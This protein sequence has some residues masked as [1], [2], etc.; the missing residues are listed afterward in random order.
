MKFNI[1]NTEAIYRRM[2]AEPDESRRASIFRNELIA[3]Y[4]GL[5]QTFGGG[6]GMAMFRQWAIYTP[7]MLA[8]G[9]REALVAVLDRLAAHDAWNQA[10]SALDDARVAFEPY[11]DRIPLDTIQFGLFP[12][13]IK[14]TLPM[15]RG[16]SGFG[17]VPGYIMVTY[18]DPNEYN[19]PRLKGAVVHELHHNVRF[20]LFPFTMMVTVGEYIIAEG[21]AES[22][23]AELYGED[24]VG[25]YVTDFDGAELATARRVIGNALH[26]TGFNEVRGYIFGDGV[27]THMGRPAVGVPNYA[28]YAIGYRVVQQY[29]K[30][31]GRTVAETTFIPA[32]AIIEESR[33][34]VY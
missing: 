6:E 30:R 4:E 27:S 17:G 33:F 22:F 11:A 2:L 19:L 18:S 24:M 3:P 1:I 10:I 26:V 9:G 7:D 21:L 8:D 5:I 13:D 15:D 25:Y 20:T 32:K 16:Y 28:G 34:F 29:L 12:T 23:A 14:K 31:T